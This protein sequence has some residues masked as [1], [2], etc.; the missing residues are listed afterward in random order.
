MRRLMVFSMGVLCLGVGTLAQGAD[1]SGEYLE[2]RSC[3]IYTGPCFANGEIGI[4]GK[5]AVMAWKV[6]E[7]SWAGQDLAGWARADH[8]GERY[9]RLR[10]WL[11][12]EPRPDPGRN[13]RRREGQPGAGEGRWFNSS[14]RTRRA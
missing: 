9:A 10:R 3:D 12:R 11:Q 5:E 7:G 4:T 13:R 8:H 2:A 1:I 14:K 6:D